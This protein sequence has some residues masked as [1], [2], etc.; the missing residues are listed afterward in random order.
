MMKRLTVTGST[1]RSRSWA[2]KTRLR[3]GV[4]QHLWPL[5]AA[6]KIR[7]IV[8][9]VFPLEDAAAAQRHMESSQ[10]IGK[11]VLRIQASQE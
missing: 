5:L 8:D 3:D 2:E 1:L 7:P 6:G 4:E 11:I 10:H 9:C